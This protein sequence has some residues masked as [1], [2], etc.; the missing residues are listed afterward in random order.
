LGD[1]GPERWRWGI[2]VGDGD[3]PGERTG[4]SE[5]QAHLRITNESL[6]QREVQVAARQL[7]EEEVLSGL[8]LEHKYYYIIFFF[9]TLTTKTRSRPPND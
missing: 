9:G 5:L 8:K 6:L 1:V 3:D 7:L 2:E 4:G